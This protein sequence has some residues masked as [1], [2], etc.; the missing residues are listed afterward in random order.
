[1]VII[2]SGHGFETFGKASPVWDDNTQLFEYE[3]NRD[4]TKRISRGLDRY[5]IKNSVLV[6]E[7]I[8]LS[9]KVRC[10]RANRLYEK[11]PGSFLVSIHGNA[12]EKPNEGTGWEVWT[13]PGET[14]SDKI[15][16]YLFNSAKEVLKEFKMRSDYID[17]DPDKESKFYILKN[18][19]CPAVLTENLFFDNYNDC[20]YMMS[21]KGR[22]NIA[23][24]HIDGI[25]NYLKSK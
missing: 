19:N 1:M 5:S 16:L 20:H 25:M 9:L 2:D 6:P 12:G 24:L 21:E 15:A 13:S 4:I 17:G 22:E 3:F 7:V 23:R 8:D 14:E 11:F 18:T 10:D